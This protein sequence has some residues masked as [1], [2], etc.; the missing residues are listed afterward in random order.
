V[1]ERFVNDFRADCARRDMAEGF[2]FLMYTG[3]S[4]HLRVIRFFE[5]FAELK[6]GEFA[7]RAPEVVG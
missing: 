7:P 3:G 5:S 6:E 1:N 2:V 4:L